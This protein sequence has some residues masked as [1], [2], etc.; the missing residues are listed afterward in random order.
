MLV[1]IYHRHPV[2]CRRVNK[3][4]A[5]GVFSSGR[6]RAAGQTFSSALLPG[7]RPAKVA[8]A[9]RRQSRNHFPVNSLNVLVLSCPTTT[10]RV[11][12]VALDARSF[13]T[14]HWTRRAPN[15]FAILFL[16]FS[17]CTTSIARFYG[18]ALPP[19]S[20]RTTQ[21]TRRAPNEFS[22]LLLRFDKM[23]RVGFVR[24]LRRLICLDTNSP[25]F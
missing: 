14:T 20:F 1:L 3:S 7:V 25:K 18:I 19:Y 17:S 12:W 15:E 23:T 2:S 5:H 8:S 16:R 21:R 13:R 24:R 4:G 11:Y 22:M 6:S 9:A 10:A